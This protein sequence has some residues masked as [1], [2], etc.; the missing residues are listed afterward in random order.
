MAQAKAQADKL[1][2]SERKTTEIKTG[3]ALI[4][5]WKAM[6]MAWVRLFMARALS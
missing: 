4:S 5:S 3:S 2:A 1:T 6:S